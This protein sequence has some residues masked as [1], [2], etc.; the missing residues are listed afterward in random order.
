MA[1]DLSATFNVGGVEMA[2]PFKIR[3]LG[4]FGL[5]VDDVEACRDFYERMMGFRV[6]DPLPLGN[7]LPED[8]RGKYGSGNGYFMRHGTD[9]HSFVIFPRPVRRRLLPHITGDMTV[10]Q[11]TWQVGSLREVVTGTNWLKDSVRIARTGRDAPGSNWH[12]YPIDPAGHT[13][14]LYYGIEQIGWD[15]HSKPMQIHR[16]H[17]TEPPELPH[18]SELEEVEEGRNTGIDLLSGVRGIERMEEKYDVGGILMGRPFKIVKVGPVRIFVPDMEAALQFYC[19]DLGLTITE[20]VTFNGHRCVFLRANTE[21]HS[22]ALYPVALRQEL[23]LSTHTTMMSIGMQ[24]AEYSQ[25]HDAVDFLKENGYKISKLP[26]ELFPGLGHNA[27]VTDPDGHLV[28]LYFNM[29][30]IGWDG[31]PRPASQRAK[32]DNDNWP[33]TLPQDAD[34]F[35]GEVYLGPWS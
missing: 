34:M 27:F 19:R 17:Y 9:H 30:Q 7:R 15:Q 2:R 11:I 26:Q 6:A 29:E 1:D 33:A 13:N 20:K 18:R 35:N 5:D 28:Q 8:E 10:N 4:H 31:K 24:V 3:R 14:E 32:I 23:G 12:F 25:L 21:H 22:L 16:K